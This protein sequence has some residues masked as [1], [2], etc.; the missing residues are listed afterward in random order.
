M[1][2]PP[3][4]P[5]ISYVDPPRDPTGFEVT[6]VVPVFN[7]RANIE[8]LVARISKALDGLRWQIIYVDDNSPDGT[9]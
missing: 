6:V 4:D 1:D 9:A 7:E 5:K 2:L 8:P 3:T